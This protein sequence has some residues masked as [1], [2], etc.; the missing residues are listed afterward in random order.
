MSAED[1]EDDD[2][3]CCDDCGARIDEECDPECQCEDCLTAEE[4]NG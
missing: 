3:F 1:Y 2:D 4:L